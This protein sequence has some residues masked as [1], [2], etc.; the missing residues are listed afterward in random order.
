MQQQRD[1]HASIGKAEGDSEESVAAAV[2]FNKQRANE[3]AS[4][5]PSAA[6]LARA[7]TA[8]SASSTAAAAAAPSA[9]GTNSPPLSPKLAG[10][11]RYV[12]VSPPKLGSG[13]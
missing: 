12:P 3:E 8:G 4:N 2:A 5:A 13:T 6:K 1:S 9:S 7:D 11:P 10:A